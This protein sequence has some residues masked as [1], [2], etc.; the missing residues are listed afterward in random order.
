MNRRKFFLICCLLL[1]PGAIAL[2]QMPRRRA[3]TRSAPSR[4]TSTAA[5][6]P[7]STAAPTSGPSVN[8]SAAAALAVVNGTTITSADI[9]PAVTAA[10][11]NDPD[12]YLR[13]FYQDRQ[14]AIREARQRALD[15]KV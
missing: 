7:Q 13:D 14:K 15:E 8:E 11:M 2:A 1:L 6:S 3:A 12:L 10:I 5:P 9:E 4:P